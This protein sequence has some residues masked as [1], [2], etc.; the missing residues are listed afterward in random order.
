METNHPIGFVD[1]R[2]GY[3][4][5]RADRGTKRVRLVESTPMMRLG[6]MLERNMPLCYTLIIVSL[7]GLLR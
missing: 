6:D 1:R 5:T 2:T 4:G 7:P 3:R